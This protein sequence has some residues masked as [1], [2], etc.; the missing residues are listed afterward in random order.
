MDADK[1]TKLAALKKVDSWS[2]GEFVVKQGWAT[3]PGA[4]D[5]DSSV[6]RSCADK[7]AA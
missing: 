1:A 2:R 4:K 6:A 7:I 5:A 3:M